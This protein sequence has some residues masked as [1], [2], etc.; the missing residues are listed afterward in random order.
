MIPKLEKAKGIMLLSLQ[1]AGFRPKGNLIDHIYKDSG[2]YTLKRFN[3]VDPQG[4]LKHM[5]G[6][7][8]YLTD[9]QEINGEFIAFGGNARGAKITGKGKIRTGK[10]DFEDVYFVK[11][12]K[13]NFFIVS[14]KC[15]KKNSILFTD[16]ECV[17]LFPDFKLLD[18][19]QVLLKVLRNN[20][21]Y[22][23]DLK[24]VVPLGGI[25]NQI[26]HNVKTII[27]DNETEFKNRIMNEFYEMKGI[28]REFSVARTP[29]QNSVA[30]RKN[31]TLIKAAKTM[32]A[33]FK[34]P[35]TFWAEAVNTACYKTFLKLHETIWV[36]CYNLKYLRSPRTRF[37]EEN[38]HIN[39]LED[40]PNVAGTGPNWIFDIDTL[41]MS[42]N[43]QLVFTGNQTNGPKSSKD[44][45]NDDAGKK[46][47]EVPRKENG[48]QDP[49]KETTNTNKLNTVS[50]PD[51]AV[52][53]SFTTMDPRR[54]RAKKN[55][56]ESMFGQDK[57]AN[58]NS[59][60][61]MFTPVSA[62]RSFYVNLGGSIPVNV[63][64]LPNADL[65]TDPLMPDLEDTADLQDTRIFS[66][67]YDDEVEGAVADF[68]TLEPTT[69]VIPIPTTKIHKD[70]LKDYIKKQKRTNHKDYQNCLFAYFLSQ[71]EP[72]KVIKILTDPSWIEAMQDELLQFRL[73]KVWR[74]VDLPKG[75]H[76][77]GTKWVY[78]NKKD[79]R[80]IVVRNKARLVAHGHTNEEGIDYDEVFSPV[81]SIEVIRLFFAYASFMR[82]IMYQMDVKSSFLYET[83]EEEAYV[84]QPHGFEENGFRR[85][86][87][88]KTL[89]IKKDNG[90]IQLVQMYV[91]DIIFGSTKKSLCIE[92]EGLMHKKFQM[93]SMEEL[94]FFLGLQV[95]QRDD[96]IFISQDKYVADILKKFDF[97]LV[98]TESTSIKTNKALLKDE[99][100]EDVDVY[101]YRSMIELLMYLIAS[102]PDIMFAVCAC[103]RFQ[104]TPKVSHLHAV[105]RIFRYLKG[106]P[107]LG[108]L[109]HKDSPFNLE[110]FSDSD[111]AR[112][113]LDRKSTTGEY[114]AAANCYGQVLWIQNQML[115]YGFNF[116]NTKI[117]IDNESIICIVKNPFWATAKS[118][119]V[120]DVKQIH[121][122][123]DEPFNDVYVTPVHTKKVFTNMKRQ[124]KDFSATVTPLF[125]SML[126]PQV[127][128]GEGSGQ[129][130]EPQPPSSIAPPSHEEQVTTVASQPQKTHT[131]RQ[132]K[133]GR[134][135]KISQSSGPPKKV[136]DEA[137]YTGEDDR[138][139]RAATT[140]TSLE[141]GQ[142]SGNINKTRFTTTL[143]ESSPSETG[144][145]SGPRCQDTTLGD[146]DAHTRFETASKQSHDPPLSKV[147]TSG[148]GEDSMEH[149]DDLTDF[150]PPT[151]HDSPFSGEMILMIWWM[152]QWR[153][154][155]E[156]LV[157]AAG[158]VNTATTEVSAAS[159]SVT[160]VGVS[161]STDEP[162]TPP[163]TI[164]T[165]FEDEDL[166]I[167]QT[168]V[169]M[170]SEKA[171]EKGVAFIDVEE[172]ARPTKILPTID[173][174]DKGKG[175][176]QE[177]EKP[178]KN[179]RMAQIQL[180]ESWLRGCM[181]KKLLNLRKGKVNSFIPMDYEVVK[182]S[183]NKDDSSGK[184]AGNRKKGAEELRLCLKIVQDEDIA[185]NY[186]TL[187]MKSPIVDWETQLLGS[188][189][190]GED[191]S[192]WKITIADGSFRFYKVFSTMLEEFDRQDLFDLH[193]LVMKRF[194]SVAPEG[195]DLIF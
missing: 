37:V 28:R 62:A 112:Y 167:A 40:K 175:I 192:Y 136:G 27:C 158:T 129:P 164:T 15:D 195:Y 100:A 183:G 67:A 118:K 102:R 153:M 63:A 138:V 13:F 70:H 60:Y 186:E 178:P 103:A 8:C 147:N 34:L 150:I 154:L 142:K 83:I 134:D 151:P 36:S 127:V 125:T 42:M 124:N 110:D 122:T 29:Q 144:S 166:T 54:E 48:V 55:E 68:N 146:A 58:G 172:Y 22:S 106:Q 133:R 101:L 87:I 161:I 171:K 81:A 121:A 104:V 76:D 157:N 152:K 77:I 174:K 123:V 23:F 116:M 86:I 32:L 182:D 188:D 107:K 92:F 5:T 50:S 149:Q 51:N 46:G 187:A 91:D 7:K 193:R 89:F 96:V 82:F 20:N 14:Q 181:K 156:I 137:V 88:D 39:F 126:V 80:G 52:S 145:G 130:S 90:D 11:K 109:Y 1:H 79:E 180:D 74:L 189:L 141:A 132:T 169:M 176:M 190:Q 99:E 120:N 148:S 73:Q 128:E 194:E 131:P 69:V 41:T 49:A 44:K 143:N 135:T 97:S 53:S 191:L 24:N 139:V 185:I 184:Q 105:K 84:C 57:D 173:P 35:T 31:R 18:E 6:N 140:A 19:S 94:T 165:V 114:V 159:A 30:E 43:Y 170:R 162:R 117:Y 98:R 17:V 12:L 59:T 64:T 4:R 115:D 95:M 93:S 26:D 155:K 163:T 66:G 10:L 177:P 33:D 72:K 75:K 85:G 47:S 111:Y 119:T 61:R 9:Y 2:S 25:E 65:P 179:L 21:M 16:T 3:Y 78:R 108:L 45:A 71:I 113:S 160:T 38:L 56:L 168:L